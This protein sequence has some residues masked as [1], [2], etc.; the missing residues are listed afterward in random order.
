[1]KKFVFF[2]IVFLIGLNCFSQNKYSRIDVAV[3]KFGSLNS[4]N[5]ATIADT[6]TAQFS[7]KE[8]KARAI[9]YWIANNI[10]I[11]PKASRSNDKKNTSPADVIRNRKTNALGF[12]LLIQEMM[13]MANIRC[14]SIDGY[15]KSDIA[16]LNDPIDE[17]NASWN[18][19]QL[20]TSPD[21]WFYIDAYSA[22]GFTD[23]RFTTF[24]K[25]FTSEYFFADRTTFNLNHFPDNISWLL[26]PG[27][28]TLKEFYSLPVFSNGA[29]I[30]GL[31]KSNPAKGFIKT[32]L[33]SQVQFSFEFNKDISPK[34][35]ILIAGDYRKPENP[36]AVKFTNSANTISFSHQFKT[37]SDYPVQILIDGKLIATY[38]AEVQE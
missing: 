4:S 14:L 20:G 3:S 30:A 5:I 8:D 33:K 21:Q 10:S 7:E 16:T 6:I 22:A 24:T 36:V 19:V 17:P 15:T 35:V 27:V 25:E 38:F 29:M 31:Q 37:E 18:V 2:F 23:K 9:F 34:E 11:D 32:K 13:S 28:K 26:G 12:S 1:M